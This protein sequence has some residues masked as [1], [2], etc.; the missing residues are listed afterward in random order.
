MTNATDRRRILEL[1]NEARA[2]GARLRSICM[3]LGVG[4]NTYRRWPQGGVDGRPEADRPVPAHALTPAERQAVLDVCHR[5]AFA[6]LPPAQIVARLLDDEQL[7][8]ASESSFYRILHQAGEQ[9]RRG[10]QAAPRHKG[11]PPGATVPGNP[12]CAGHGT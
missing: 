1:V 3:E 12:T 4:Q 7:Y 9:R 10:R 6:S 11:P 2:A 5:P 8:L